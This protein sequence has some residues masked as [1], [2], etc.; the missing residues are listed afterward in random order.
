MKWVL[1]KRSLRELPIFVSR[2]TTWM[3]ACLVLSTLLF[4]VILAWSWHA[5]LQGPV[6]CQVAFSPLQAHNG[7]IE[8]QLRQQHPVEPTFESAVFLLLKKGEFRKE[9]LT[10]T[11]ALTR[12][13]SGSYAASTYHLEMISDAASSVSSSWRSQD[14]KPFQL[15]SRG[16]THRWFPFDVGDFEFTLQFQPQVN[17][18]VVRVVNRVPGFNLRCADLNATRTDDSYKISFKVD[19]WPL[20]PF[21]AIVLGLCSGVFLLAIPRLQKVETVAV[22]STSYF[23]SLW[24]MR[25]IMASQIGIFPTL[26]DCTILTLCVLM[27]MSLV[28]RA[29]FHWMNQERERLIVIPSMKDPPD[30]FGSSLRGKEKR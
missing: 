13:A 23:F 9:D 15:V 16:G 19:R 20:V 24:S 14:F 1:V 5:Q 2:K 18:A 7:Y 25:Q 22:A 11:L 6:T 10:Q 29:A 30:L 28:W 12:S 3:A 4:L 26:F 21:A 17:P 8:F 27:T